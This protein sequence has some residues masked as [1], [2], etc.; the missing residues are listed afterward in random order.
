MA[1]SLT[2]QLL[3]CTARLLGAELHGNPDAFAEQLRAGRQVG[4]LEDP[5]TRKRLYDSYLLRRLGDLYAW[6]DSEQIYNEMSGFV[7]LSHSH[8]EMFGYDESGGTRIRGVSVLPR[9]AA[10]RQDHRPPVDEVGAQVRR[11]CQALPGGLWEVPCRQ[12]RSGRIVVH[13]CAT[14]AL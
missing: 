8:M 13:L 11:L 1:N 7:H 2:R 5:A 14:Q 4:L 6:L 12:A 10:R 9:G 3:D